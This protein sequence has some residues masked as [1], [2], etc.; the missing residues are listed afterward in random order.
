MKEARKSIF[1]PNPDNLLKLEANSFYL[2]ANLS[3]EKLSIKLKDYTEWILYS[4]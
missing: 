1:F 4:K 3:D 2:E